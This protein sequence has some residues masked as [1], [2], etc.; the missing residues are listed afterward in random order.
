MLPKLGS[1]KVGEHHSL[2]LFQGFL[3]SWQYVPVKPLLQSQVNLPPDW[4]LHFPWGPQTL[5]EIYRTPSGVSLDAM[6]TVQLSIT[7]RQAQD[8]ITAMDSQTQRY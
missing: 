6:A 7:V 4:L 1:H 5:E 2:F 8:Q 3:L